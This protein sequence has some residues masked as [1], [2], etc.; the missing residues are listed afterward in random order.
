MSTNTEFTID[1]LDIAFAVKGA[2]QHPRYSDARDIVASEGEVEF[3]DFISNSAAFLE[4]L[5]KTFAEDA[6]EHTVFAYDVA[7]PFGHALIEAMI[8]EEAFPDAKKVA[9]QV[10]SEVSNCGIHTAD[11]I[12]LGDPLANSSI[13][14]GATH[15]EPSA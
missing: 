6:F 13:T 1:I 5:S 2:V 7:E 4:E 12:Y 8:D 3:L 9:L 15:P 10:L 14:A 11:Q